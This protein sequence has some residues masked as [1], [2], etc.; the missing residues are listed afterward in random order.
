[1]RRFSSAKNLGPSIQL[2]KDDLTFLSESRDLF[3]WTVDKDDDMQF[4][5]RNKVNVLIT[6]TPSRARDVLGYH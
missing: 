2:L 4:C 5:E 1:M 6:N 3:V